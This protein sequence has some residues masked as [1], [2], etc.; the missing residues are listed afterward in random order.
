M[1]KGMNILVGYDGSEPSRHALD[2]GVSLSE[3]TQSK[4]FILSVVSRIMLPIFPE[5]G[6]GASSISTAQ[7]ITE[8]QKRMKEYFSESLK[9]AKEEILENYPDLE[10]ETRLLEG[11]PSSTIVEEA[12]KGDFDLLVMGSRGL[13]GI[14][15]WILGSTSRRVVESC[16]LPVL[17]IK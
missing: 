17:I 6:T 5:E 15:G 11:R 13:G 16:K 3:L 12:E 4:I 2:Q 10:V 14:S 1:K 7:E 9:K 8:L